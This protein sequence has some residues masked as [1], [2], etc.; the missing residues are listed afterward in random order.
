MW[1][2]FSYTDSTQAFTYTLDPSVS[3]LLTLWVLFKCGKNHSLTIMVWCGGT[4][5]GGG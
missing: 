1:S 4:A 2:Q 3:L 5:Q